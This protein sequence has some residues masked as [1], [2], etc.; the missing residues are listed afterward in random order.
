MSRNPEREEMSKDY[1]R[2][3]QYYRENRDKDAY[4]DK[5]PYKETKEKEMYHGEMREKEMYREKEIYRERREDHHRER[6]MYR[7]SYREQARPTGN[8]ESYREIQRDREMYTGRQNKYADP[9]RKRQDPER[10]ERIESRLRLLAEDGN[11]NHNEKEN[12]DKTSGDKELE[13]LRSRLLSKRISKELQ[14][15]DGKK[16]E[17]SDKSDRHSDRTLDKH[18]QARRNRL[19]KAGKNPYKYTILSSRLYI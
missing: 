14:G 11:T 3:K 5:D 19:I 7:E 17:Y 4:R 18:H 8:R 12:R 16:M 13:D 2:E 15:Q 1:Y 6:E 10:L 9:E